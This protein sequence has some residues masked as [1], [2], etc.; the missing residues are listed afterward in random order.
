[1]APGRSAPGRAHLVTVFITVL[2]PHVQ[3]GHHESSTAEIVGAP[4]GGRRRMCAHQADRNPLPLPGQ[5]ASAAADDDD[6]AERAHSPEP[7]DGLSERVR[8]GG[9]SDSR[10]PLTPGEPGTQGQ[11]QSPAPARVYAD[12]KPRPRARGVLH[13]A[14]SVAFL[15]GCTWAAGTGRW[16]LA[17]GFLGKFATYAASATFHLYPFR[18][19][20]G[21]TA[22]YFADLYCIPMTICG[23]VTESSSPQ[24]ATAGVA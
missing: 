23:G 1:M 6:A 22:A 10:A 14:G 12:G 16:G 15:V 18:S 24:P 5:T 2:H 9:G 13:G 7:A 19:V 17:L 21:V 11:G 4:A 8:G 3:P 20:R